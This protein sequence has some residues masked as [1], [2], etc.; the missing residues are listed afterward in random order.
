M[1]R[2]DNHI[3]QGLQQDI[4]ISQHPAKY[5]SNAKNI[6]F[7][8]L[9]SG[10]FLK[11]TNEK[12]TLSL[13]LDVKEMKEGEWVDLTYTVQEIDETGI[14]I[15][16]EGVSGGLKGWL[17]KSEE[18]NSWKINSSLS[19]NYITAITLN[20]EF[21][22]PYADYN[23]ESNKLD[24]ILYTEKNIQ[25]R[26]LSEIEGEN[27]IVG[28]YDPDINE[29]WANTQYLTYTNQ[30]ISDS[31]S[32]SDKRA[33]FDL[34]F[35]SRFTFCLNLNGNRIYLIPSGRYVS[36][37]DHR[38]YFLSYELYDLSST[39]GHVAV[40]LIFK[41]VKDSLNSPY[42]ISGNHFILFE[43]HVRETAL[44]NATIE[45]ILFNGKPIYILDKLAVNSVLTKFNYYAPTTATSGIDVSYTADTE[46]NINLFDGNTIRVSNLYDTNKHY[47]TLDNALSPEQLAR[48]CKIIISDNT[49]PDVDSDGN[50]YSEEDKLIELNAV[51]D[52]LT[53]TFSHPI[54]KEVILIALSDTTGTK[55]YLYNNPNVSEDTR[56]IWHNYIVRRVQFKGMKPFWESEGENIKISRL[57]AISYTITHDD[58]SF[59]PIPN[60]L[61]NL[62]QYNTSIV[63]PNTDYSR[64]NLLANLKL[65]GRLGTESG[66]T[67]L[68]YKLTARQISVEHPVTEDMSDY[69]GH[70]LINNYLIL[71]TLNKSDNKSAIWRVDLNSKT[72]ENHYIISRLYSGNLNFNT[73]YP[74]Q[75]LPYY[76]SEDIQKVYWTDGLNTPRSINISPKGDSEIE[77]YNDISFDFIP[78]NLELQEKIYVQKEYKSGGL[79]HSGVI[80]YALTYYNLFGAETPIIYVTPLYYIS[81][82]GRGGSPEETVDNSFEITITGF[83]SKFSRFRLYSIQ[84]TSINGT[85]IVKLIHQGKIAS[86]QKLIDTGKIGETVDPYSLL[87]KGGNDFTAETLCQKDNTLFF[88]NIQIKLPEFPVNWESL[89]E[90]AFRGNSGE[91]CPIDTKIEVLP[92]EE[93]STESNIPHRSSLIEYSAG[94]QRGEYYRLGLQFQ[95]E[96]GVWS[97]PIWIKDVQVDSSLPM[98]LLNINNYSVN[99][100]NYIQSSQ[101]GDSSDSNIPV[102]TYLQLDLS[103][104]LKGKEYI[105]AFLAKGYRKVRGLIAEPSLLYRTIKCQGVVNPVLYNMSEPDI[106]KASWIFRP[107]HRV[108]DYIYDYS[109]MSGRITTWWPATTLPQT[110]GHHTKSLFEPPDYT[111]TYELQGYGDDVSFKIPSGNDSLVTFNSPDI[112][113]DMDAQYYARQSTQWKYVGNIYC[114]CAWAYDEANVGADL[115]GSLGW[116]SR[117]LFRVPGDCGWLS[118]P[119]YEANWVDDVST[120]TYGIMP[121]WDFTRFLV[122][123]WQKTGSLNNDVSRSGQGSIL[124]SKLIYHYRIGKSL[125]N[126]DREADSLLGVGLSTENSPNTIINGITYKGSIDTTLTMDYFNYA[127]HWGVHSTTDDWSHL[128]C[129][130]HS[131][132]AMDGDTRNLYFWNSSGWQKIYPIY[133]YTKPNDSVRLTSYGLSPEE[134]AVKE[135]YEGPIADLNFNLINDQFPIGDDIPQLTGDQGLIRM[136]Y[137]STPHLVLQLNSL[138]DNL[139]NPLYEYLSDSIGPR[140]PIVNLL[141]PYDADSFYGG[142]SELALSALT[143][144]PAGPAVVLD[145]GKCTVDYKWGDTYFNTWECLKTYPYTNEDINRVTDILTFACESH[146]NLDGRYDRNRGYTNKIVS[147][148]NFN[149]MNNVYSQHDNYFS[150]SITN[151]EAYN[152][153]EFPNQIVYS[154]EKSPNEETDTWANITLAS[155]YNLDGTKGGIRYLVTWQDKIYCF[156]DT[157]I[158]LVSFNPRVQIPTSDGT[159][160]EISNNYKLEGAVSIT[161]NIGCENAR[162]IAVTPNGLYF[163]DFTSRELYILSSQGIINLSDKCNMRSCFKSLPRGKWKATEKGYTTQLMYEPINQDLYIITADNCL[164]YS[165]KLGEFTSF[166][167]YEDTYFIVSYNMKTF[168]GHNDFIEN[169]LTLYQMFGGKYNVFFDKLQGFNLSFISNSDFLIDKIFSNLEIQADFYDEGEDE[170]NNPFPHNINTLN[171]LNLNP[172]KLFDHIRVQTEYQDTGKVALKWKNIKTFNSHQSFLQ[173]N[174]AKKFRMWRIDIPRDSVHKLDRIRNN[175]AKVTLSSEPIDD[176]TYMELHS[177]TA[178]Y[179]I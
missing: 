160:I 63:L 115:N 54:S 117:G 168:I 38:I 59:I 164:C 17:Q 5:L 39:L 154:L 15:F 13:S 76:E 58:S 166:M 34:K 71:F 35:A 90:S 124:N 3:F 155:F 128:I 42:D 33:N 116:K 8:T 74:I 135:G 61:L 25:D 121:G 144:I 165:E 85:P 80:Q 46:G 2:S 6:R 98:G 62:N 143:W 153:K 158:S 47:I 11:V 27:I 26:K 72:D 167:S 150:Y 87:T 104:S 55:W 57:S 111:L 21:I 31:V 83:D 129:T 65:Y 19:N 170:I 112:L 176:N 92:C 20:N 125:Y 171:Q 177:I 102:R 86:F 79:F 140:L 16:G 22:F 10:K 48:H 43:F 45:G 147:P 49:L 175:W 24:V 109:S 146:V 103:T 105:E 53:V 30:I 69:I 96:T 151:K 159:P 40:E 148:A 162:N 97:E 157:R 139:L 67:A 7:Q 174:M 142:I 78:K 120:D 126:I 82:L 131:R 18:T 138:K 163:I 37:N 169:N 12:G 99:H 70:C 149:L 77:N 134:I 89:T 73:E 88:G 29:F 60:T 1:K 84:R 152:I 44:K 75:A 141:V 66:A 93:I 64:E 101:A 107:A 179:H 161:E 110:V 118:Q 95:H 41:E 156:Q 172:K 127:L 14:N 173:T 178:D 122:H 91:E 106:M 137:Q 119:V 136:K 28:T 114:K 23:R 50:T 52:N 132:P 9:E 56:L 51:V 68:N 123:M 81:P 130:V 145:T 36:K 113:W 108:T 100:G 32:L 4:S 133:E 94:F